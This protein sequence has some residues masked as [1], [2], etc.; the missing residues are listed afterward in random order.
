MNEEIGKYTSSVKSLSTSELAGLLAQKPQSNKEACI[1]G[2]I[3]HER[4]S[5]NEYKQH[6]GPTKWGFK[7]FCRRLA[8][9]CRKAGLNAEWIKYGIRL[10]AA[11]VAAGVEGQTP[12]TAHMELAEGIILHAKPDLVSYPWQSTKYFELKTQPATN[13]DR[14]QCAIFGLALGT[15]ITLMTPKEAHAKWIQILTEKIPPYPDKKQ[16]INLIRA[17]G[18]NLISP[19]ERNRKERG[20]INNAGSK[21]F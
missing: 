13:Y 20:V 14:V 16:V 7:R 5:F 8:V 4:F 11:F 17:H 1:F 19:R 6:L 3:F 9:A 10:A 21:C 18:H 12:P 2:Q 15:E